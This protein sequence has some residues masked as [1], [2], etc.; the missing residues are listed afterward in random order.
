MN[1]NYPTTKS[2]TLAASVPYLPLTP[3][4]TSAAVIILTSFEPSPTAIVR[5]GNLLLKVLTIDFLLAGVQR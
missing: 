1:L 2:A 3:I 4:P 5:L